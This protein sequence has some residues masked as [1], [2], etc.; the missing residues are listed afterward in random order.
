MAVCS[1]KC[2]EVYGLRVVD[3]DIQDAGESE[4]AVSW[5]GT[6]SSVAD[7]PPL[8]LAANTTRFVVLSKASTMLPNAYPVSQTSSS[9]VDETS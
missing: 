5:A 4:F 8:P 7:L 3:R 2:A 6:T 9:L 1:Y